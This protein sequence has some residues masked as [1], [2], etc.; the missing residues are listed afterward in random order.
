LVLTAAPFVRPS[1]RQPLL[2]EILGHEHDPEKRA[3]VFRIMLK[4]R[5][6]IMMR[7]NLIAS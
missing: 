2:P 6:E 4:Q 7:S 1:N 5:D 3:P